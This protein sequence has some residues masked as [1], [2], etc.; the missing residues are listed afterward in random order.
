MSI[1][2][3]KYLMAYSVKDILY[4]GKVSTL[5]HL[6]RIRIDEDYQILAVPQ[7]TTKKAARN[8]NSK[9]DVQELVSFIVVV[10]KS[11]ESA[12]SD[13]VYQYMEAKSFQS[14]IQKALTSQVHFKSILDVCTMSVKDID[15]I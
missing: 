2:A 10:Y 13:I 9:E 15:T 12:L 1:K 11:V 8:Q 7:Y 3:E 14:N 4:Q 6:K 5:K